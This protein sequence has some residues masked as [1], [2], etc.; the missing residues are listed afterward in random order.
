MIDLDLEDYLR[1]LR[2]IFRGDVYRMVT[3]TGWAGSCERKWAIVSQWV[4]QKWSTRWH[5][6]YSHLRIRG[7]F[8]DASRLTPD[9]NTNPKQDRGPTRRNRQVEGVVLMVGKE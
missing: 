8:T 1:A 5:Q 4:L 7:G 6:K 3:P 9:A 2:T